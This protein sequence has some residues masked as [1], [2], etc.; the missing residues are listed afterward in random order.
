M[1]QD[2]W[3]LSVEYFNQTFSVDTKWPMINQ[4]TLNTILACSR[5]DS[6][7]TVLWQLKDLFMPVFWPCW[8]CFVPLFCPVPG[9]SQ[10]PV[11]NL[12]PLFQASPGSLKRE[13]L[14]AGEQTNR[15]FTTDVRRLYL[16]NFQ[17]LIYQT[18]SNVIYQQQVKD[19]FFN[20]KNI[21]HGWFALFVA[22]P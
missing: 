19:A 5:D 17:C 20:L 3:A 12:I 8:H 13:M 6:R 7:I 22:F 15:G 21:V 4:Q 14:L 18:N 16:P 11:D 9:I 10:K 1:K 2:T